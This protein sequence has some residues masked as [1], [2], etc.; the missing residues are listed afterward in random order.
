M[1]KKIVLT[2]IIII[3]LLVGLAACGSQANATSA[4]TSST[5]TQQGASTPSTETVQS[6]LGIGILQMAGTDLAVTK[7]Q[8]NTLLPLWKALKSLSNDSST[9]ATEISALYQQIQDALTSAQVQ[10]IGKMTKI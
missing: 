3:V 9:S 1:F 10:A 8:A 2:S 6:K 4:G 5:S 7:E